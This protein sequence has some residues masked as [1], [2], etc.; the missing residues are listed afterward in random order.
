MST[1]EKSKR[2]ATK[3]KSSPPAKEPEIPQFDP[4]ELWNQVCATDPEY[5]RHVSMRGG[6]TQIDPMY[7][8]QRMTEMFGPIGI[9]WGVNGSHYSVWDQ[10]EPAILSFTGELWY[11]A[12]NG[13]M[14]DRILRLYGEAAGQFPISADVPLINQ[15]RSGAKPNEDAWKKCFTSALSKGL[16]RLGFNSDVFLGKFDDLEYVKEMKEKFSG[17][18]VQSAPAQVAPPMNQLLALDHE[19]DEGQAWNK[20]NELCGEAISHGQGACVMP[21]TQQG[22]HALAK[23]IANSSIF[24]YAAQS[25]ENESVRSTDDISG[26][27]GNGDWTKNSGHWA[28]KVVSIASALGTYKAMGDWRS[29]AVASLKKGA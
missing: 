27:K 13:P 25:P 15:T 26:L 19:S 17:D 18:K 7:Q 28:W 23:T 16:S 20:V 21:V 10:V 9:G 24:S 8:C 29:S 22:W 12:P 4:M 11:R 3:K 5:T 6:F 2:T 14:G 1:E